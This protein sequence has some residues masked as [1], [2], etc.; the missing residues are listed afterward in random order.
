MLQFHVPN[1][2]THPEEHAHYLRFM[3][4][5]FKNKNGLIYG[6]PSSYTGK[7]GVP[8]VTDVVNNN[9]SLV[10]IYSVMEINS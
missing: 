6:D 4:L 2:E 8:G 10:E 9:S 3:Y 5:S 1:R 7:R